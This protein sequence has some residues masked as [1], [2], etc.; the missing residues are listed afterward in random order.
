MEFPTQD[1]RD[2][3]IF[4]GFDDFRSQSPI[5]SDR[6]R[7][8]EPGKPGAAV[9]QLAPGQRVRREKAIAAKEGGSQWPTAFYTK[10]QQVRQV[11][12]RL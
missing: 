6:G 4:S 9:N 2:G 3:E 1:G 8:A 12:R 10:L 11:L 7:R 5:R